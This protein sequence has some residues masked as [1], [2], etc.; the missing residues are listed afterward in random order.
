MSKRLK[1]K[2]V[3]SLTLAIGLGSGIYS[4]LITG[5]W[6]GLFLMP[7]GSLMMVFRFFYMKKHRQNHND[8]HLKF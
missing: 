7:V 4:F 8:I 6:A 2:I 3:V 5:N 1:Y